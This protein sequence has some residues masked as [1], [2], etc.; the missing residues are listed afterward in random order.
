M[1]ARAL[2]ERWQ[3]GRASVGPD[4]R[5]VLSAA[6]GLGLVSKV[7]RA[8]DWIAERVLQVPYEDL[9]FGPPQVLGRGRLKVQVHQGGGWCSFLLLPLLTLLTRQRLLIVG[10]PGRGKTSVAT[11]MA[12]LAGI[13]P[14]EVRRSIQRGH[15]QLTVADL[16]G[17]PLPSE[18]IKAQDT[19]EVRVAWRRWISLPV[20]VVDEYNRIPTKTQ[21]ALLSLMAEGY[22]ELFEQVQHAGPSSWFLTANDDLGGGTFE[23]IEAL[24]DRIDMVVRCPP[25]NGRLLEALVEKASRAHGGEPNVPRDLVLTPEELER[26]SEE[27]LALAVP[28]EVTDALGFFAGQLDFCAR[29]AERVE[30]MNKDTLHL[31]GRRLAQVCNEDCP[32]DKQEHLCTQSENGVSARAYQSLLR[33]A[34]ALAW[35]RRKASVGVEEVRALLPWALH[36]KLRPNPQSAFFQKPEHHVYLTDRVAWI[37]QLF[38]RALTQRAFYAPTRAPVLKLTLKV[39]KALDAAD[40]NTLRARLTELEAQLSRLLEQGELS[41]PLHDD[42]LALRRLHAR[43]RRRLEARQSEDS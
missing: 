25:Y 19:R 38:D 14:E 24:R 36:D 27:V 34:K 35:F 32:L 17:A 9:E 13:S 7:R 39:E 42:V 2:V 12:L 4:G 21:S 15:P 3:R 30:F 29:A 8:Y 23:V 40:D 22:A 16:L 43:C 6:R 20:K 18:L 41:A 11:L 28:P 37:H 1:E 5:V 10:G 33:Y 26:A 31:S